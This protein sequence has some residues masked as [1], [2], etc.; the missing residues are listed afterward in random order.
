VRRSLISLAF[1][2]P[3][4]SL[5]ETVQTEEPS[6][7][8]RNERPQFDVAGQLMN[9]LRRLGLIS[10]SSMIEVHASLLNVVLNDRP[11]DSRDGP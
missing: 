4:P 6:P 7:V 11:H 9:K 2:G 5:Y 8:M 3:R 10:Y 1:H